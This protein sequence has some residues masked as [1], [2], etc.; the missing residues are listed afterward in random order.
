MLGMFFSL[1]LW[2]P[3][4]GGMLNGLLTL[5]GAWD[6]LRTDPVVKFFIAA[7]TFYGMSTFEGP[8][9]SIRAVNAF[10]HYSDWTIGHVHSGALGW[11]GLM[12]AGL[13]YWLTPRLYGTKLYSVPM[14]NFHFWIGT[15][16]I[17]LYVAAMWVSGIMQGLM[18]NATNAAGTALTYPN[19]IETLTS[20]RRHDGLPRHRWCHVSR[21]HDPHAGEPLENRPQW[22]G[23]E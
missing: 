15:F 12:A 3:S 10:S 8:L 23:S 6:K 9:L 5:R 17:L 20:I 19:F 13:F 21:R 7:V 11:N 18:L 16:G 22:Q 14:A 2:A 4:W 1:M